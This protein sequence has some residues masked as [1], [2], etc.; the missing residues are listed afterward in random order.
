[1]ILQTLQTRSKGLSL[2]VYVDDIRMVGRTGTLAAM[3]AELCKHLDNAPPTNLDGAVYL[4]VLNNMKCHLTCIMLLPTRYLYLDLFRQ[5][6]V[7]R[8]QNKQRS[9]NAVVTAS[10]HSTAETV[11]SSI[12]SPLMGVSRTLPLT[13]TSA[14]MPS[15]YASEMIGHA[16]QCVDKYCELPGSTPPQRT[17]VATPCIDDHQ[18]SPSDFTEKKVC[19]Q[20]ARRVSC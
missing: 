11:M 2:S 13:K 14:S 18:F 16:E 1:M 15:S 4:L 3:C 6:D 12:P 9:G 19:L 5:Q 17:T 20:A 10:E 8:T 7:V